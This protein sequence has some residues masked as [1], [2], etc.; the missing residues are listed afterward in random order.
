M[1]VVS[2]VCVCCFLFCV[3]V[4]TYVVVWLCFIVV[5]PFV[6]LVVLV[7][8]CFM[9]SFRCVCCCLC[10]VCVSLC[11]CVCVCLCVCVSVCLCVCV[12]VCLCVC[13]CVCVCVYVCMYVCAVQPL[14]TFQLGWRN[15][16][17]E[18]ELSED[19]SEVCKHSDISTLIEALKKRH[20]E[21][22]NIK[23]IEAALRAVSQ[24]SDGEFDT[25]G[26]RSF[27]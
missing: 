3:S 15:I 4:C 23:A 14:S 2:F 10:V 13:V 21:H 11:V 26:S 12:S 19:I 22:A 27:S 6:F 25:E 20:P 5:R 7:C 8:V 1:C 9:C 16:I 24:H 18:N 17:M